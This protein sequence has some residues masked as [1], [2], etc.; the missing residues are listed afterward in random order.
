[1][2]NL[3]LLKNGK[4]PPP[5]RL[6]AAERESRLREIRE[7]I[8]KFLDDHK[9]NN[10]ERAY[11]A[12]L[13]YFWA[14]A[15]Y[16]WGVTKEEYPVPE[17]VIEAYV[18]EQLQGMRASTEEAMARLGVKKKPGPSKLSTVEQRLWA[19][20]RA[21][22]EHVRGIDER[23]VYTP[24]VRKLL[25]AA[26]KDAKHRKEK[27]KALVRDLLEELIEALD[28]EEPIRATMLRALISVGFAAGGR[29][30][31]ELI[32]LAPE[33]L[34]RRDAPEPPGWMFEWSLGARKT[35]D[36][37]DAVKVVPV[38]GK[39]ALWLMEWIRLRE[40]LGIEG[41]PLFRAVRPGGKVQKGI[42]APWVWKQITEL[43]AKAGIEGRVTPHSLR[44]GYA[45]QAVRDGINLK[46][47][48]AMTDHKSFKVFMG[49]VEAE[50]LI[51]S[52]AGK[53]L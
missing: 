16:T 49:Y 51:K 30:V 12:G 5:P 7:A 33:D 34:V 14:W 31:S 41:A 39:A 48:M 15:W 27:S 36:A 52:D 18:L 4:A 11:L 29:R 37:A 40:E 45:T 24:T 28:D 10:S 53:L 21:H 22:Q 1:M 47:A 44:A 26:R 42:S 9:V 6:T 19:L 8:R 25:K 35:A 3:P 2:L 43:A 32:A 17:A 23:Y 50:D 20:N 13:R 38:R 46:E